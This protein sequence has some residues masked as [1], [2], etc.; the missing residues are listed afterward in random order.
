MHWESRWASQ[1][2]HGG[3]KRQ[4]EEM[5]QERKP[6]LSALPLMTFRYFEQETRTVYDDG[7]IQVGNSYYAASPAPLGS[8]VTVR[9]FDEEIQIL[10]TR[11]SA[12]KEQAGA[13]L[14]DDPSSG[15]QS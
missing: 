6:Y 14:D 4:V 15:G 8:N 10:D 9:I 7:T 11:R 2:I 1:L 12:S 3:A 5:F 13:V